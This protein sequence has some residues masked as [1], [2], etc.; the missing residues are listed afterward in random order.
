MFGAL[1]KV[2]KKYLSILSIGAFLIG[3]EEARALTIEEV[4]KAAVAVHPSVQSQQAQAAA[5]QADV[6]TARQQFL[7]TPSISVEQVSSASTDSSYGNRANVQLYRLQQPLWTGGRLT[8]ALD[9]AQ[10]NAQAAAEGVS[11]TRQQMAL[12]AIQAW[13]EWL[14]AQ[15]RIK[16]QGQSIEAHRRLLG[17]VERRVN[18][19]AMAPA[20]LSLTQ[21][22]L[23]QAQALGQTYQAQEKVARLKLVQLLGRP[24]MPGEQ[25]EL[26]R[27]PAVCAAHELQTLAVQ[28]SGALA[29]ARAQRDALDHEFHER[30]GELMPEVYVRLERQHGPAAFGAS[31]ATNNRI[32][33]GLSSRLGAGLSNLTVLQSLEKRREAL[34][35]EH[36]ALTRNLLEAVQSDHEQWLSVT[37]RLPLL[38]QAFERTQQTTQ[39]WD[40]QFLAGRRSWVEVMNAAREETQAEI[41]WGDARSSQ[42]NLQWRLS[43]FCGLQQQLL[44]SS[45]ASS[46]AQVQP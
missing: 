41:D 4:I 19:G 43:L 32:F 6:A 23:D 37:A 30:R 20:E 38:Q 2:T 8:A 44:M 42:L 9:K 3:F 18:E 21:S 31:T 34:Q 26:V 12:R 46:V 40:R 39:A 29:R 28:T 25:P 16:A 10:S 22:R 1:M 36:E 27:A 24:L 11:D 5:A 14:S 45:S 7:P 33:V 35:A 13:S 17:V 15:L